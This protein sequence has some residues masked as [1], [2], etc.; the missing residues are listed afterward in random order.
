MQI[1]TLRSRN[2]VH[3]R[4]VKHQDQRITISGDQAAHLLN[5]RLALQRSQAQ[6]NTDD[7]IKNL[8]DLESENEQSE[9]NGSEEENLCKTNDIDAKIKALKRELESQ[10]NKMK[11]TEYNKK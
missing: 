11:V 1:M 6:S 5:R 10:H 3:I 8:D 4:P 7:I 2:A 9:I